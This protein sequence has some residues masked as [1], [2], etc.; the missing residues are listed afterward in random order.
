MKI[1]LLGSGGREHALAYKIAQSPLC[2]K[3]FIA[4]GNPGTEKHGENIPLR[5]SD[6]EGIE[7]FV[8]DNKIDMIVPGPE[9]PLVKGIYDHF[10]QVKT[11]SQV[12][13]IGPS[14]QGAMLEG[15]KDFAKTFMRNFNIPTSAYETFTSGNIRDAFT[16]LQKH[17]T[18]IVLKADGL[19]AGKG[20][21]ICSTQ[22]EAK[23]ELTEMLGGKFG[24]AGNKVVIEEY[25]KGIEMSV[26]I[27]TDGKNYKV[28]PT[29]KDYKRIGEDDTGLNTGG[30][31]AIAPVP[32]ADDALM[33]KVEEQIIRPTM[34]GL[35]HENISYKGFI[36][37]GLMVVNGDPYVIEYNCRLGDP[38]AEAVISLI[39]SDLVELFIGVANENLDE[40]RMELLPYSA[41]TIV[42]A[43]GGYPEKYETGKLIKNLTLTSG[44]LV[45]HAG[46][47]KRANGDIETSG[48]RVLAITAFDR[49]LIYAIDTA[50]RNAAIISFE[51]KYFR[52]DIGEDVIR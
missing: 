27:I 6:F 26:F 25:L 5:V 28:L 12:K 21:V 19:A 13:V 35:Q 15:S 16:F 20:V 14:M 9:E 11:G 47:R 23:K 43:S 7:K 45:F 48:G 24:D 42:L 30:M 36:Y 3:L 22:D 49:N 46:T 37:F 33:K 4:P 2:E 51:G 38:E 17:S 32:F 50:K 34:S 41:A 18:P 52:N 8:L 29:A 44:C 40:K 1:L 31:G 39:K 10:Q